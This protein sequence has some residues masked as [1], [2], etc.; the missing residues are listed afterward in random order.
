MHDINF[1]REN[2]DLFDELLKKRY[3]T[4]KSSEIISLDTEKRFIL[5]KS[6]ELRAERK[7]LSSSFSKLDESE[8]S[9]LQKKVQLIKNEIDEETLKFI[10]N[11]TGGKFFRATDI[12]ALESIYN[13]IDILERSEIEVKE[14]S[15]YT[16]IYIWILLPALILGLL[17]ETYKRF[18]F[19]SMF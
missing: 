14:Y 15:N 2:P 11:K 3:I 17:I 6:Q 9:N 4:P 8:K 13:A 10:A 7:S 18:I 12:K 19:R 5:T 1:I 16:E